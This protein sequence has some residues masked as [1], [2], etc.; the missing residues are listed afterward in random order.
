MH[1]THPMETLVLVTPV[2]TLRISV[3]PPPMKNAFGCR[4]TPEHTLRALTLLLCRG[5]IKS[6]W[7]EEEEEESH[8][9]SE[10]VKE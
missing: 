2:L 3:T 9:Y 4:G 1:L 7:E 10:S 8:E 6:V 5:E